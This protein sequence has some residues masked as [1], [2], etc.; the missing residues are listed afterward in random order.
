MKGRFQLMG[1]NKVMAVVLAVLGV[2]LI[3]IGAMDHFGLKLVY[4]GFSM[5][6]AVLFLW[7]LMLWGAIALRRRMKRPAVRVAVTVAA[8]AIVLLAGVYMLRNVM[9]YSLLLPHR[10]ATVESPGGGSVVLMYGWDLLPEDEA[11]A[12][13]IEARM[14]QR[15]QML[16][17]EESAAPSEDGAATPAPEASPAPEETA[18]PEA[19][20]QASEPAAEPEA[21]AEASAADSAADAS[22]ELAEETMMGMYGYVYTA[23]PSALGIFYR[24][25]ADVE[26]EIYRGYASESRILYEWT[27]DE[28]IRIYLADAEPGDSG[29]IVVHM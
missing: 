7:L 2:L 3:V 5:G 23:Y 22:A 18:V 6:G 10:F 17:A 26:G 21:S 13:E 20:P 19:T 1:F 9:M 14:E 16:L 11:E 15:R 24:A 12:E 8:A 27:D 4:T 25:D 29:E 28:T